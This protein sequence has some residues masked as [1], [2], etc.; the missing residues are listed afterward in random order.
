MFKFL[1][2]LKLAIILVLL[3]ASASAHADSIKTEAFAR[4][5]NPN[6]CSYWLT[7]HLDYLV[8]LDAKQFPAGS[9]ITMLSKIESYDESTKKTVTS[10][11]KEVIP[12]RYVQD[13]YTWRFQEKEIQFASRGSPVRVSA[14]NFVWKV[15]YPDGRSEIIT[16]SESQ[17]GYMRLDFTC[18]KLQCEWRDSKMETLKIEVVP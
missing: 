15:E 12:F 6:G 10:D 7:T 8:T 9:K 3:S 5:T 4:L 18:L 13:M 14:L 16:G 2:T 11:F 17:S 1:V